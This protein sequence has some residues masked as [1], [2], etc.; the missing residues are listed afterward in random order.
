M[1]SLPK[2]ETRL[3]LG[4]KADRGFDGRTTFQLM[5]AGYEF[6]IGELHTK[7]GPLGEGF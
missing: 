7:I 4:L 1:F 3:V 5:R 2:R 6:L